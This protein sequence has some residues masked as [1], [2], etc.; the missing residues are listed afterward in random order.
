MRGFTQHQP[1]SLRFPSVRL[2]NWEQADR[3]PER[4][5]RELRGRGERPYQR[6]ARTMAFDPRTRRIFT[7]TAELGPR[8]EGQ[9]RPSIKPGT[10]M[11]LVY[12]P[13]K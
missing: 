9:R 4:E 7:V 3:H 2:C 13:A 1:D 12:A 8:A 11:P 6:W 5:A 10:F